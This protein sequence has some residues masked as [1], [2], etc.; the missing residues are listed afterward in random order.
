M[1]RNRDLPSALQRASGLVRAATSMAG[2]RPPLT[3]RRAAAWLLLA[4]VFFLGLRELAS[5]S[6]PPVD[7][8]IA[9]PTV[10][11]VGVTDRQQLTPLD[12]AVLNSD[13]TSVQFG[14]VSTRARYIG[15]CAAAGWTTLGAGRRTSVGGLCD[16]Q[17]EQRRVADWPARLAAARAHNG[18]AHLGTL[19][20][21]VPFCIAAVGPGAAL[22]AARPDGTLAYYQTV[23]QFL[24]GGLPPQCPITVIDAQRR[25]NEII[26]S[27]VGRPDSVVIVT[28]I[29]PPAG[30]NDAHLQAIY[31]AAATPAGWLT[32]SSTRREGVVNL[33]DLT[34]TLIQTANTDRHQHLAAVDGNLFRARADRITAAA[35]RH[36]L[37]AI[38]ALSDAAGRADVILI[39]AAG[40]ML[41]ALTASL[42][43]RK[44]R[45]SHWLAA[46]ATMIPVTMALAGALPWNETYAP[47][48]ALCLTVAGCCIT[49]T[50]IGMAASEHLNIS[51]GVV[52]AAFTTVFLTIDA[53]L[54]AVMQPGSMLNSKP[55]NGGRWYGFGNVT[56]AVYASATL[57]LIGYLAQR[58]DAASRRPAAIITMGVVGVGVV[59]CEGW[60]SMGA[61][62]GGVLALTP[63]ALW[64][65]CRLAGIKL[66]W[67]AVLACGAVTVALVAVISWLD[68]RRGPAARSHLGN[69]VQRILDGDAQEIIT[70]K[71]VAAA[72]SLLS[73]LG[74]VA[75][76]AGTGLWILIFRVLGPLFDN[77]ET[78]R[79]V[80]IA[81][82]V[83]AVVGTLVN[84][85]G[86]SIWTTITVSFTVTLGASWIERISRQHKSSDHILT[87]SSPRNS[88]R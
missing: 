59:V 88:V 54:G 18:D 22:A 1:G 8:P 44:F 72:E 15:D 20:S 11:V 86:V 76:I 27:L 30:S 21:A 50:L 42:R 81:V 23:E 73:P 83:V 85:G 16:P 57:V 62:F 10:F 32:S 51:I 68:W 2:S 66:K 33:T 53:A 67:P 9:A 87:V 55:T 5:L 7:A 84:D 37:A 3:M 64:L 70:R 34:A 45:V 78:T 17:V 28:G 31:V 80:A 38:S 24:A 77:R 79:A 19:A 75:M 82:L 6:P 47:T 46:A 4:G 39:V 63:A 49:L 26:S 29:G 41:A 58:L 48:L 56:F 61:D 52:A 43:A 36:H 69:F 35:A 71:A 65:F 74:V 60:P 14:A 25:T 40:V 13:S 12:M